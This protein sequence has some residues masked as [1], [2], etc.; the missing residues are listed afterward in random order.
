[1]TTTRPTRR[2]P[3]QVDR[4]EEDH[5]GARRTARCRPCR[6]AARPCGRTAAGG[7]A[8]QLGVAGDEDQVA[9]APRAARPRRPPRRRRCSATITPRSPCSAGSPR[10]TR[11]TTPDAVPS[12]MPGESSVSEARVSTRS[13]LRQRQ[14]LARPGRR[15]T[16]RARWTTGG[17]DG[18]VEHAEPDHAAVAGHRA[19]LAACGG[20][21]ARPRRRRAPRAGPASG[22]GSGSSFGG[23]GQQTGGGQ[24]HPA[25]V[26]GHLQR[27]RAGRGDGGAR[28][29]QQHRAS[30]GAVLRRPRRRARRRP[31]PAAG[32]RRPGSRSARRSSAC[33]S[34]C[35]VSSSMRGVL[36]QPAQRHLQDVV[37]LHLGSGRTPS[38]AAPGPAR[39][40]RCPGSPRS[41]RRCRGS[42]SAGPR[43]GAAGRRALR[44][45]DSCY[46]RRTT[47]SRWAT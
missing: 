22:P 6:R 47:S 7:E 11:L 31:A 2:R 5:P 35:S 25:R 41:P 15:R 17:S 39:C 23:A 36:G 44:A 8:Q 18:Q 12:A 37:G 34:S 40:R 4:P 14:E 10:C 27:G 42:R 28:R 9:R 29:L 16:G 13:P 26:V 30:R 20:A 24:Q 19:D 3:G 32:R 45:A 43:P 1:M 21:H 38:S 46:R 33:S